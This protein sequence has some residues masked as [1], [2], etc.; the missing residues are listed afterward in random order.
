MIRRIDPFLLDWYNQV[1]ENKLK[2]TQIK[3]YFEH[4]FKGSNEDLETSKILFGKSRYAPSLFFLHLA[5]EKALKSVVVKNKQIL[6]PFTHDLVRLSELAGIKLNNDQVSLLRAINQFN[7]RA[8]Y[9]DYKQ[10]FIK[11][12]TREYTKNFLKSGRDI[13]IWINKSIQTKK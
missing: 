9:D 6:P 11:K 13:F 12:A 7:I 5:I 3:K 4:Y 10:S 8:R 1:M 2:T